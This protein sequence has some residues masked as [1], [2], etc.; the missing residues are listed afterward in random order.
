MN[1]FEHQEKAKKKTFWLVL[2]FIIGIIFII[3]T[4]DLILTG[5]LIY[6]EPERYFTAP[7]HNFTFDDIKSIDHAAITKLFF[8]V[9]ICISPVVIFI[10]LFGSIYKMRSLKEGGIAVAKMVNAKPISPD[11]G[12]FLEKR[13]INIVEEMSIASGT[14][15]PKLFV[16]EDNAINAF[17]AGIK[18][19]DTVMVVTKG[20]LNQLSRDELQSVVGHEFSH[21]FNGDMQISLRLIGIL[22]GILLIGQTGYF[23]LRIFGKSNRR[24]SSSSSSDSKSDGRIIIVILIIGIGLLIVG[25]IGLF[26]GRLIKAGVSRQRELLADASS[27]QF[28]RNPQGLVFALR[29][30]LESEKGTYLSD[31]HVEDISHLCFCPPRWIMFAHLLATHPPLAQ[32]IALLDP[33][34]QYKDLPLK[35]LKK[36]KKYEKDKN[37]KTS[38]DPMM[39]G[40]AI[41][42]STN[43]AI[44]PQEVSNSIGNP[45]PEKVI[46]AQEILAKI[47]TPLQAA[48]HDPNKVALVFYGLIASYHHEDMQD[49][50]IALSQFLDTDKLHL[51]LSFADLI[52]SF[53]KALQL[54]LVDISL[55]AFKANLEKKRQ[56]I[57]QHCLD[58]SILNKNNL[59]QFALLAIIEKAIWDKPP[60]Q[61]V[62]YY[63][64]K[65]VL[66]D[67]S[68]LL[69]AIL[70]VGAKNE[71]QENSDFEKLM[72]NFT[73]DT[74]IRPIISNETP[75]KLQEI[76]ANLNLLSPLRKE[77][78]INVLLACIAQDNIINLQEAELIRGIAATLDC[79]IPPIVANA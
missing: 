49:I 10:I 37:I 69:S 19:D 50:E 66:N 30:I 9:G 63:D 17:V 21:I 58:L 42:A 41:L 31:K 24:T 15:V 22:G 23:L 1:F 70:K 77:T 13:F 60:K 74:M 40:A 8:G 38:V 71:A 48:A 65:P 43:V 52:E 53:P 3:F 39:M 12:D 68:L 64:F 57:Y 61:K 76:L 26:F 72:K 51:T 4:I 28:T 36:D 25:Y 5:A 20:A 56:E 16:M 73:Q 79:P 11:T 2:Y 59:F 18:P 62:T 33:Q 67:I 29:R 55:P 35:D 34:G 14:A 7:H 45:T 78:L 46:I 27:V 6:L 75:I 44:N 32:R 54:S 47:P